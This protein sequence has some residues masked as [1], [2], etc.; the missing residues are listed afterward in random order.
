MT[1]FFALGGILIAAAVGYWQNW[2]E[3]GSGLPAAPMWAMGMAG[4]LLVYLGVAAWID[5]YPFTGEQSASQPRPGATRSR[6]ATSL[7]RF[8]EMQD[9]TRPVPD[10]VEDQA[11]T[12][13]ALRAHVARGDELVSRSGMV[14]PSLQ[15]SDVDLHEWSLGLDDLLSRL[16]DPSLAGAVPLGNASGSRAER[17]ATTRMRLDAVKSSVLPA[18]ATPGGREPR[19]ATA[20]GGHWAVMRCVDDAEGWRLRLRSCGAGAVPDSLKTRISNW[21]EEARSDLGTVNP[22]WPA[23]VGRLQSLH[24]VN[25]HPAQVDADLQVFIGKLRLLIRDD[26]T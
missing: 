18:L 13:R 21:E 4:A 22:T 11:S 20:V 9:A 16:D 19:R 26:L 6:A 5:Q 12:G 14:P 15:V 3:R 8:R 23:M 10:D 7:A 1:G 17:V 25:P 2:A 24:D